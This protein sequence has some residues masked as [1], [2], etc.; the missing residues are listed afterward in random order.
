LLF[1]KSVAYY[2]LNCVSCCSFV[3]VI[4][5]GV[6]KVTDIKSGKEK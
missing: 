5:K 6:T 3:V 2:I 1:G 4:R